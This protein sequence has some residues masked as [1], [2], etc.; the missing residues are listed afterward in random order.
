MPIRISECLNCKKIVNPAGYKY[1]TNKCQADYRYKYYIKRWKAGEVSGLQGHG[2]VSKH[3]KRYLREK[4]AN[5][6]CLCGWSQINSVT[7]RIPLVADHVDGNWANNKESN[8]RLICPNCDSLTPTY[9]GL[10]RGKGREKRNLS[11]RAQEGRFIAVSVP[12]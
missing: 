8:L 4:Y 12:E 1:C 3:I 11:K 10:N 5:K 9:A 2:V 7:G 6:C